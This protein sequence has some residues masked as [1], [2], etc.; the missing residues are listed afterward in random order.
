[1]HPPYFFVF[2]AENND[3]YGNTLSFILLHSPA[4]YNS[5]YIS[6]EKLWRHLRG[7]LKL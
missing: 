6:L 5:E 3:K 1:M 4:Y 2:V 7:K